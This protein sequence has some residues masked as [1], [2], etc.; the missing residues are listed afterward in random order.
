MTATLRVLDS[1]CKELGKCFL[2]RPFKNPAV[3]RYKLC[4]FRCNNFWGSDSVIMVMLAFAENVP[5]SWCFKKGGECSEIGRA[6]DLT[7]VLYIFTVSK[8]EILKHAS[9]QAILEL[10]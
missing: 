2:H 1:E 6:R 5:D 9:H 10:Y 8:G 3:V 4:S 7:F